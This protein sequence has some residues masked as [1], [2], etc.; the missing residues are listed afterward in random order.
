MSVQ[1]EDVPEVVV[2][3]PVDEGTVAEFT[4]ARGDTYVMPPAKGKGSRSA[5]P[6]LV[7]EALPAPTVKRRRGPAKVR[8]RKTTG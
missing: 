5:K 6:E 7:E 2:P 8:A 3:V 4:D 1:P